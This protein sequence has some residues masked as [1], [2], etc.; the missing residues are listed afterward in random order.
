MSSIT[1][2]LDI[3]GVSPLNLIKDEQHA[4]TEANFWDYHFIIPKAAPFFITN[5]VVRHYNLLEVR[6]L[7]EGIDYFTT[8]Q[9][10]GATRSLGKILYGGITLNRTITSGIVSIDYQTL[11]GP[12]VADRDYVLNRLAEI[13]Y[14]PRITV[15]ETLTNVQEVFP[16]MDHEQDLDTL[17]GTKELIDSILAIGDVIVSNRDQLGII[18]HLTD[19]N[20]PHGVNL[21]QLGIPRIGNWG[22]ATHEQIDERIDTESLINPATLHYA[23]GPYRSDL[24]ALRDAV[25]QYRVNL[26]NHINNNDAHGLV[27]VREN[28]NSLVTRFND[29]TNAIISSLNIVTQNLNAHIND[30]DNP[31]ELTKADVQLNLVEN[32][33]TAGDDEVANR[34]RVDKHITLRQLLSLLESWGG[35]APTT[36]YSISTDKNLIY[37]G[38]SVYCTVIAP[39][40][41]DG[42]LV[43]WFIGHITTNDADFVLT[44]GEAIISNG[45]AVFPV[46]LLIDPDRENDE[47]F[48]VKLRVESHTGDVVAST[49]SIKVVN[50]VS[51]A[52]YQVLPYKPI[53][54]YG[55]VLPVSIITTEIPNGT[56]LYW[57]IEHL[58][59]ASN[60]FVRNNGVVQIQSNSA[61]FNIETRPTTITQLRKQFRILARLGSINGL[62]VANSDVI[63]LKE[64]VNLFTLMNGCCQN[65]VRIPITT[66]ALYVRDYKESL[67]R[68]TIY[69]PNH[70]LE[71]TM[72]D[73]MS[74][75]IPN[76]PRVNLRAKIFGITSYREAQPQRTIKKTFARYNKPYF[77]IISDRQIRDVRYRI[78]AL[79]TH[80]DKQWMI[81]NRR[82]IVTPSPVLEYTMFDAMST[83]IPN[84]PR[85]NLRAKVFCITSYREAQPQRT[86]KKT[87]ARYIKPYFN[88]M[89]ERRIRDVRY[90][91]TA[92][93]THLD[94][95]WM[96]VNRR[97][98]VTPS[99][100]LEYRLFD[101][102]SNRIPNRPYL[103]I[104][105]GSHQVL[106]W[107]Y[108]SPSRTIIPI[109]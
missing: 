83:R 72:F 35:F 105:P 57:T 1:Y 18:K 13:T 53:V 60:D 74:T 106:V 71:Y 49:S 64:T 7:K 20:N 102:R 108:S 46:D 66:R 69:V 19:K 96:I 52:T 62:V 41:A 27:A 85:V 67:P 29:T 26:Q 94:K 91:I 65:D 103:N 11:G 97:S 8:L 109:V 80:L 5:L 73:A 50:T 45:Q 61:G 101:S 95:Q 84:D 78:T 68:R 28:H 88:I 30:K 32:I 54:E 56:P 23:L 70:R 100:V 90:R 22:M 81:V 42:E 14:N 79:N 15:W 43:F 9:Y 58:G 10:I 87:F 25:E 12:W 6:E 17:Y 47:Y 89:S 39:N 3:T 38:E 40:A 93:N 37:E 51:T 107:R 82:S 24:L 77:S 4:V 16:P 59:S 86:I 99:P 48:T 98:I 44:R 34:D 21:E 31:H 92:L 36:D 55:S 75:R 76:D 2:P 33:A 104:R 63:I